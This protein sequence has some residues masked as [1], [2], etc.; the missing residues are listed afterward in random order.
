M[1]LTGISKT[2]A[3]RKVLSEVD[4]ELAP[5]KI[6][7]LL[8]QNGSGKSTLIKILNGFHAPDPGGALEVRG[9][10]VPLPLG[11]GAPRQ[12]GLTFVHQDLG[13]LGELS[14]LENVRVGRYSTGFGRRVKWREERRYVRERL[15][16]FG[17]DVDPDRQIAS[18]AEADRAIVAIVRALEQLSH[19]ERGVLILDEPTVYLPRDAVERLFASVREVA[20]EG[21]A[22]LVVTHRL[23]EV[24]QLASEVSVLR[25]GRRVATVATASIDEAGL[26]E[27]IL[28][29]ALE[30]LYPEPAAA[31]GEVVLRGRGLGGGRIG[32]F[33]FD[34]RAGEILGV[35]GLIGMGS[36]DLPY[37]LVGV[38]GTADGEL[39]ING[40]R[41]SAGRLSPRRAL[42]EGIALLPADRARD[43]GVPGAT[44]LE[45]L[46]LPTVGRFVHKGWLHH[47]EER[48][49]GQELLDRFNVQPPLP[50]AAFGTLSGGNQQKT[51]LAKWFEAEPEVIILHEPTQGVDVGARQQIF[52]E[53]EQARERGTAFLVVSVE[54]EELANLCDRV[55]VVR[56]GRACAELNGSSLTVDRIVER[57]YVGT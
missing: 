4:L 29:R 26:V 24:F 11:P 14:I 49:L 52:A 31:Y 54:Y 45:N 41:L 23:D 40:R 18:L 15:R 56:E 42:E 38:E 47:R 44:V 13:L 53:I 43:G 37:V 36:E 51:L 57:C 30:T 20:A 35:T 8:G 22:V 28:G 27:Q 48:K 25:D 19:V 1:R 5:G 16:R 21:H 34:L 6:H 12:L 17:L 2:F 46:T 10:P 32:D 7:A 33:D 39:E 3:G 55:I 9:E 50:Q